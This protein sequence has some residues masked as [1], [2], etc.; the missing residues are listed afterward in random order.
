[1]TV[2][3]RRLEAF[4]H[5]NFTLFWLGNVGGNI[6]GW[7]QQVATG[8]LVLE[9]TNSPAF[10]GLNALLQGVP[11]IV[12]AL[13]GGVVADRFDRYRLIIVAQIATIIPDAVLAWLVMTGNVRVEHVFVYSVVTAMIGGLTNPSRQSF[14]PS[15]VPREA[16]L[17]AL[18]LN[19]MVWQGSA[20]IGPSLAGLALATGGLSLCFNASVGTD[21][22][23][24]GML[25]LVRVPRTVPARATVAGWRSVREGLAYAWGDDRLRMLLVSQATMAF[26][27]RP[28]TQLM[29]VFARDVFVVGPQGLGVMLAMPAI[30]TITAA[31]GLATIG[32][33]PL[34]RTFLVVAATLACALIGFSLTRNFP[35]AL[36]FLFVIGGCISAGQTTLNTRIQE[37]V[38][39]R[40][41]GRVM[42]LFMASNQGTWRLGATP[43]GIVADF[44]GA[45]LAVGLGG[46]I[47]LGALGS[48]TRS[49]SLWAAGKDEAP[50]PTARGGEPT[51]SARTGASNPSAK[52]GANLPLQP[53]ASLPPNPGANLALQP[54]GE[55]TLP[56]RGPRPTAGG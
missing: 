44:F 5:R 13:V 14:V 16:L 38:S 40:M 55:P 53:G 6:G 1:M 37:L 48:L 29:P 8:W 45:P 15:L 11:L 26:F 35:L 2:G 50:N 49:R 41:R 7:M 20:I 27:A 21:L 31:F 46:V 4:H 3:A 32:R 24:L 23:C 51:P 22:L 18:A 33:L 56:T 28:Y 17:S 43:A 9:L 54:G 34:V 19:S 47:L 42:S 30:G 25:L 36:A 10:L 52:D 12:F 39:E